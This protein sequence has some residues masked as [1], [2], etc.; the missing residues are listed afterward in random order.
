MTGAIRADHVSKSYFVRHERRRTLK[1]Q[2]LRQYAPKTRI[3]ALQD[4]SFSVEPGETYGIVGANGSG[5]STLLKLI[6]GTARPTTGSVAVQ[7]R[8]SD[9][10]SVV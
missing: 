8:V 1:E 10:K 6:A 2:L 9:R 7:G 4:V 5:K 3:D